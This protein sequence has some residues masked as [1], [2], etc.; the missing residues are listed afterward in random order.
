MCVRTV[1]RR[2]YSN[3][4]GVIM[5]VKNLVEKLLKLPQD[6]NISVLQWGGGKEYFYEFF[7]IDKQKV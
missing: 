4:G 2:F 5:K 6:A 1:K 7:K 3:T